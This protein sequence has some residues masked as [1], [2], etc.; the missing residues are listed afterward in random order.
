[1]SLFDFL[2]RK[3]DTEYIGIRYQAT[4][5]FGYSVREGKTEI[6]NISS[7]V[8]PKPDIYHNTYKNTPTSVIMLR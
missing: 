5:V 4:G 2:I 1:M 8:L 6:L 3:K 7:L